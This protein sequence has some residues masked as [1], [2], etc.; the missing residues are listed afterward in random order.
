MSGPNCIVTPVRAFVDY[1]F[2]N[3]ST[4]NRDVLTEVDDW[5][6][7]GKV[8]FLATV[9]EHHRAK[10]LWDGLKLS[11]RFE[12]MHYSAA[13]GATK[14]DPLFYERVQAELPVSTP[15]EVIFLDDAIRNV[16][17]ASVFGWRAR[18]FAGVKDLQE[19]LSGER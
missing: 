9:Q 13:L 7:R 6:A 11:R 8:A 18:H 12:A 15:G 4:I 2:A 16:E 19:A 17:A 5:R 1:W 14:P 10:H 3:D